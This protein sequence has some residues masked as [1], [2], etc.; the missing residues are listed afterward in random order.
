[1]SFD[2]LRINDTSEILVK[3]VKYIFKTVKNSKKS[4]VFH[5]FVDKIVKW[6]LFIV[7]NNDQLLTI[8]LY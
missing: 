5:G 7:F 8:R 6:T 1:M 2:E 4:T 3:K